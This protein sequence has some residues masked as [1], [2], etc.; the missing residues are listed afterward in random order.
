MIEYDLQ[1]IVFHGWFFIGGVG[2]GA[3]WCI[4]LRGLLPALFGQVWSGGGGVVTSVALACWTWGPVSSSLSASRIL[5]QC[6]NS[7]WVATTGQCSVIARSWIL[8]W[9]SAVRLLS[10][11]CALRRSV[12][13]GGLEH[14]PLPHC[15]LECFWTSEAFVKEES[16]R[17]AD[18]G[19]LL[20]RQVVKVELWKLTA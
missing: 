3:L 12:L 7:R 15:L 17:Y 11:V 13:V 18:Y 6:G 1:C 5:L 14:E 10:S 2:G 4:I 20:H 16:H 9:I 19:R 8:V